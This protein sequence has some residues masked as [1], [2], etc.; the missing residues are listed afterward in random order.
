ME[1]SAIDKVCSGAYREIF[2]QKVQGKEDASGLYSIGYFDGNHVIDECLDSI[3]RMVEQCNNF[4]GFINY[5]A[6]GGGT[7]SGF[8]SK[9]LERLSI[10]YPNRIKH[11]YTIYPHSRQSPTIVEPYNSVLASSKHLDHL[12][13]SV[14]LD[15]HACYDICRRSLD[16]V[17]PAYGDINY[18]MSQS[19][20]SI[21][22]AMRMGGAINVDM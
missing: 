19:I 7:G 14:V 15:N 8:G 13:F 3:R 4:E 16:I 6:I 22:A 5:S 9:L 1:P 11:A 2:E 10:D 17:R 20:S 21:T 18:L 12:N